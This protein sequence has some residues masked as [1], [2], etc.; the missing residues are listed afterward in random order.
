MVLFYAVFKMVPEGVKLTLFCATGS[1]IGLSA[2][3]ILEHP[4]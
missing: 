4:F 1:T 2:V 3:E